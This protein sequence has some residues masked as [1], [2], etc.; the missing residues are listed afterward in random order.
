MLTYL[1]A[2]RGG[3]ERREEEAEEEEE[4]EEEKEKEETFCLSVTPTRKSRETF[5]F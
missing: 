4:E 2:E 3:G 5:H 1:R